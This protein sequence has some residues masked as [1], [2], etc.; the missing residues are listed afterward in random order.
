MIDTAFAAV[1]LPR[2]TLGKTIPDSCV[3]VERGQEAMPESQVR[4]IALSICNAP[5]SP[6]ED[7][8]QQLTR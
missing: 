5:K 4:K 1:V 2:V 7:T 8:F 3:I 6:D